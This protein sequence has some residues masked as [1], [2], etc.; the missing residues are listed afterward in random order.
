MAI[1][2]TTYPNLPVAR[3]IADL[4][5]VIRE[6]RQTG[7]KIALVPTMGALH[8]GHLA[9]GRLAKSRA[10]RIVYSLFVNPRQFAPNEDLARYPRTESSDAAKLAA[11]GCDLLFA[12]DASE[13]YSPDAATTVIVE[14]VT[15]DLET[16]FR[17]HFFA[18]VATV[19]TKLLMQCLPDIAIFGE[20]DYQQLLTVRRLVRDLDIPVEIIGGETVREA[21]GL[22]L[23]SRNA[24]LS[25][26]DRVT[27]GKL[28]LV[29]RNA[30]AEIRRGESVETVLDWGRSALLEAGFDAVDYFELRHAETLEPIAGPASPRRLLAAVR[31]GGTRLIDNMPAN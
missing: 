16:A 7:S 29:M 31:I 5:S 15:R 25:P 24:Y 27:A 8:E 28:N 23:S 3:K 26:T 12:P 19:V 4:R 17:P 13:M 21:D 2:R 30:I 1:D 6:W 14:G 11:L 9:L 22:A 20:K 18:G 10:D